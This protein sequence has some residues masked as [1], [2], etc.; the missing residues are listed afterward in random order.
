MTG[1]HRKFVENP[2]MLHFRFEHAI[3]CKFIVKG[4][5]EQ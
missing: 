4:K 2:E 3:V 1:A 5:K